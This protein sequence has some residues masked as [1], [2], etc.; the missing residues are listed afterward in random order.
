MST[1]NGTEK[2]CATQRATSFEVIALDT[3]SLGDRSYLVHD[4]EVAFVIDPQRD[5]DRVES[6]LE[7]HRVRL[8][9]VFETHIHNDYVTGGFALAERHAA[10][11]YV[12]AADDVTFTRTPISDGET[13]AVGDR[14]R[15]TAVATPGH[16]FTHLAFA[17]HEAGETIGDSA[18]LF[19]GGSLLYGATGRPD[20]LGAE[21][22]EHLAQHQHASAHRIAALLPGSTDL[23]PT[24][25]FGSFCS[26]TQSEATSSTIEQEIAVN[27]A[28]TQDAATYVRELLAGLDAWPA[29]Y[30]HMA[31]Q[32]ATGPAATDL[33]L[34]D[35]ADA[36]EIERRIAQGEWVVDLRTRTA[37]AAGHTPGAL[38][39]GTDG[40]LAT[41]LGW[42]IPWGTALTLLGES[43]DQV[44]EA[45]RE[46][47][48]IG[49]DSP[50]AHATGGPEDWG[51][52][53]TGHP[54][55]TFADL[56]DV[57][58][59]RAVHLLDVRRA[60]EFEAAHL[61]GAQS[62]PLHELL[63]RIDEV[64]AG[65]VWVHCAGGYRASIAASILAAAG[66]RPVAIDDAFGNAAEADLESPGR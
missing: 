19:S 44:S 64:P 6:L 62:I 34:P 13:V 30:V 36:T 54:T 33:A 21:H 7:Q 4:G 65:E 5:L 31:P 46:L 15:V 66:R 50:V 10:A 52:Q 43:A 57:R 23:Y 12:N 3:A 42:L 59:H 40:A 58:S 63:A 37:F 11:Y 25:G 45:I 2:T 20:L 26:A 1:S 60:K 16:T 41:Y 27:P 51:Q 9:A 17:L 28:L 32:N 49:V 38:N 48:R 22:A 47:S 53:T 14:M 55:A 39:F 18:A 24:H 56:A 35:R 61:R 29:Y 8:L